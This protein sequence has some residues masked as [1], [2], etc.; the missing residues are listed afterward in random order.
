MSLTRNGRAL[1]VLGVS[2]H[3]A[4]KD[5]VPKDHVRRMIF[6]RKNDSRRA[7][8]HSR[9]REPI[10]GQRKVRDGFY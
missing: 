4:V 10:S 3:P 7:P 6:N 8:H 2:G 5:V 9:R 1:K